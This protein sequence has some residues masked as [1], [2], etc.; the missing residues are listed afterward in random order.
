MTQNGRKQ[1]K[2]RG[3]ALFEISLKAKHTIKRS[4]YESLVSLS[5]TL[6][7]AVEAIAH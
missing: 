1:E 3:K 2:I 7:A 6:C 4:S 5:C